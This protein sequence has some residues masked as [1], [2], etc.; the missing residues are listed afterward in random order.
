MNALFSMHQTK[1]MSRPNK[2][3]RQFSH[4]HTST[5]FK[6]VEHNSCYTRIVFGFVFFFQKDL[7]FIQSEARVDNQSKFHLLKRCCLQVLNKS[8][9]PKINMHIISKVYTLIN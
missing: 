4:I 6:S 9:K 1:A 5:D 7:I 2:R 8:V 3:Y